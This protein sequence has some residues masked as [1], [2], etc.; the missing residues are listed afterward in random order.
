MQRGGSHGLVKSI[1]ARLR[2]EKEI[3]VL[4]HYPDTNGGHI[5]PDPNGYGDLELDKYLS[6]WIF[7]TRYA[8]VE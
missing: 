2:T 5:M 6:V 1:R 7:G 3:E 8:R 4:A